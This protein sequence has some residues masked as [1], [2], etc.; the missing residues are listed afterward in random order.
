M[1]KMVAALSPFR[2][3][4]KVVIVKEITTLDFNNFS[5]IEIK[6]NHKK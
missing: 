2:Y 6:I 4:E 3:D 1:T 5:S